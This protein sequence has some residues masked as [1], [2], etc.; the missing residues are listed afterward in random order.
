MHFAS[1]MTARDFPE[2]PTIDQ[3]V[4]DFGAPVFT[5]VAQPHLDEVS[6]GTFGSSGMLISVS[7]SYC[8]YRHPED[9]EDPANFADDIEATLWA[10]DQA[11][12]SDQPTWFMD[13][14]RRRRYPMLWEAVQTVRLGFDMDRP[15]AERLAEHIN[16]VLINTIENR[17]Q[18]NPGALPV[19]DHG[20][21]ARHA[22]SGV[23]LRVD[24]TDVDAIMIDTDP[25]VMGWAAE[26]DG[27]AVLVAFDRDLAGLVDVTLERRQAASPAAE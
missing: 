16:H 8:V 4:Q 18:S 6:H 21:T 13:S 25:D 10:I 1:G 26:I 14:L 3:V 19:L 12:A 17:R 2:P 23:T 15:L 5:L 11:Q 7:L 24:G 22:Q 27:F 9:L 20:V